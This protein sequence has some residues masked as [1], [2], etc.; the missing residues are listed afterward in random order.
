MHPVLRLRRHPSNRITKTALFHLRYIASF[1]TQQDAEKRLITAMPFFTG[2]PK[3][4]LN[5][6]QLIQNS[7]AGILPKT[8]MGEHMTP[9]LAS[10]LWLPE[11]F[12]IDFSVILIAYKALNGLGPAY[13]YMD[14]EGF[15]CFPC[16]NDVL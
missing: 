14:G 3:K 10:L 8:K 4:S 15:H 9:G 12:R 16:I 5:S 6:L 7:A 11:A 1:L 2:P 13:F